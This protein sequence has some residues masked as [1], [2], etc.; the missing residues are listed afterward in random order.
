MDES[1]GSTVGAMPILEYEL[2]S[3]PDEVLEE[4]FS[5]YETLRDMPP[6]EIA[7]NMWFLSRYEDVEWASLHPA[8]FSSEGGNKWAEGAIGTILF[9]AD[10]PD[11]TR[12]RKIAVHAFSARRTATQQEGRIR[13]VVRELI[14]EFVDAGHAD[15]GAA[16]ATPLPTRII[17]EILGMGA[18]AGA[19]FKRWADGLL[20]PLI[21][22]AST[23]E[24]S[25][26]E[27]VIWKA[28]YEEVAKFFRTMIAER[29]AAPTD[30]VLSA[31]ICAEVEP[32]PTDEEV[33]SLVTHLIIAGH[34]TTT[35]MLGSGVYLLAQFPDVQAQ[36]RAHPELMS[37]AVEEM[38]RLESPVQNLFR[39]T[40]ED[41]EIGGVT[42]PGGSMVIL[43]WAS[44]NRDSG[45]FENPDAMDPERDN[46]AAH[47]SF[48]KGIHACLGAAL[49]RTEGR[50]AFEELLL[51]LDNIQLAGESVHRKDS[52]MVFR[53]FQKLDITF[54]KRS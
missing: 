31:M 23:G 28:N 10:P 37:G 44:A 14:D 27:R 11:H 36:L 54:D 34:E 33:L 6:T 15:I 42:I 39:T 4:P 48:G 26:D 5:F 32:P 24:F 16:F 35:N 17:A 41:V 21:V 2:P 22:Y 20:R 29:R 52:G 47:L 38:L 9:A 43:S 49:A 25:E 8:L 12:H 13:E 19:V 40:N 50:I 30:D 45:H 7:T 51:R 1:V 53:G 3:V 18:E 46:A